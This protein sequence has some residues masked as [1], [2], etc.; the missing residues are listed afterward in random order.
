MSSKLY[1]GDTEIAAHVMAF[2]HAGSDPQPTRD[3]E[4]EHVPEIN[5]A[6][7]QTLIAAAEQ[8]GYRIG[9]AAGTASAMNTA[10][11]QVTPVLAS[12]AG[13]IDQLSKL[14]PQV[15]REAEGGTVDL[16]MA[17][18]RRILHRELSIDPEALLGLVRSA[19]ERLN[20]R[21]T[22]KLRIS[23]ADFTVVTAQRSRLNLPDGVQIVADSTLVPG[24]AV[25]ETAR[26]EVD[27]SVQTQLDEI[28][29]GLT[30]LVK[31]EA[32]R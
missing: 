27:A 11:E 6:E 3:P 16:A 10:A 31:R 12:L 28:H 20:A 17:V 22:H 19:V 32:R 18:A 7:I 21:E 15:R 14:R 26:G 1:R 29:R 5:Q 24:S 13:M 30:D 25:F 9:E 4:E 2:R 8:R 23:P